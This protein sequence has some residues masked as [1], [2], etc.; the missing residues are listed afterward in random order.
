MKQ[1][2]KRNGGA[3]MINKRLMLG[4]A[5]AQHQ[6]PLHSMAV[7]HSVARRAGNGISTITSSRY[8]VNLT[9]P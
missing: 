3:A 2:F 1:S 6:P 7:H 5:A 4:G 9:I 8:I